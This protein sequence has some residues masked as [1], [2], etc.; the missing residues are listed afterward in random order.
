MHTCE[1]GLPCS[2]AHLWEW[3]AFTEEY[4]N[5]SLKKSKS[6]ICNKKERERDTREK[7]RENVWAA[8]GLGSG[9]SAVSAKTSFAPMDSSSSAAAT[10]I[11]R[12]AFFLHSG[13]SARP[14]TDICLVCARKGHKILDCSYKNFEPG[15]PTRC[16][17]CDNKSD[18]V[19][20]VKATGERICIP[21]NINMDRHLQSTPPPMSCSWCLS[22]DHHAFAWRC[23]KE[24]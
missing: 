6:D 20:V 7:E 4:Y 10:F 16:K 24:I 17:P 9:P 5:S 19:V 13:N 22:S 8:K 18:P 14:L 11:N 1:K 23:R 12:G 3:I 2:P 21:F 15:D